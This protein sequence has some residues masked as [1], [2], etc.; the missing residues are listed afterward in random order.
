MRDVAVEDHLEPCEG[1][2]PQRPR[3]EQPVLLGERRELNLV[4][5]DDGAGG[6]DVA[7][8]PGALQ[9]DHLGVV[10]G[11]GSNLELAALHGG[12]GKRWIEL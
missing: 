4:V 11:V 1:V 6:L 5:E 3:V 8:D 2:V 10:V 12:E 9:E 7:L